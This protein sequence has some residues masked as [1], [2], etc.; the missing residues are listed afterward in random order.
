MM[1]SCGILDTYHMSLA[2]KGSGSQATI[3]LSCCNLFLHLNHRQQS[4]LREKASCQLPSINSY[5]IIWLTFIFSVTY[6]GCMIFL[7]W[8][9]PWLSSDWYFTSSNILLIGFN[10]KIQSIVN[11]CSIV[12]KEVWF[13]AGFCLAK[14]LWSLFEKREKKT[15]RGWIGSQL[16]FVYIFNVYIY[17]QRIL[18]SSISAPRLMESNFCVLYSS[19]ER[20]NQTSI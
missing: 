9:S 5:I 12:V 16:S 19:T 18:E 20:N 4:I 13:A 17:L 14:K 11:K 2:K 7:S 10:V 6:L 8:L 1:N 15:H 3:T